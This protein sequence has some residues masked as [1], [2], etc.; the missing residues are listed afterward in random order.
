MKKP[1]TTPFDM[2][3]PMIRLERS[4][5][6]TTPAEWTS[7]T[8]TFVRE[9][10]RSVKKAGGGSGW[11][12]TEAIIRRKTEAL[13]ASVNK[14]IESHCVGLEAASVLRQGIIE[15]WLRVNS[16][17]VTTYN[18]IEARSHLLVAAAIWILDQ[19]T[20]QPDWRKELYPLL[21]KDDRLLDAMS[22]P[23]IWH[24]CYE[25]DL[26][27]SVVYVLVN[28][29]R[30]VAPAEFDFD[31]MERT[32][33]NSLNAAGKQHAD[34][35]SRRAFDALMGMISKDVIDQAVEHFESLFWRWVDRYLNCS[36]RQ[37]IRIMNSAAGINDLVDEFNSLRDTLSARMREADKA[38]QKKQQEARNSK[39][40]GNPLLVNP[41]PQ[42]KDIESFL[43]MNRRASVGETVLPI[44]P[45]AFMDSDPVMRE[46]LDLSRKMD[47][48]QDQIDE[49]GKEFDRFIADKTKFTVQMLRRGH[50]P[51][52]EIQQEYL[53]DFSDEMSELVIKDPYEACF[54]L[55][56]L[57][58]SGSDLP[59]LYG[60]GAGLMIEVAESLPWG[61]REYDEL[62]DRIWSEPEE[63]QLSLFD[64]LK[65]PKPGKPADIP[66]WYERRYLPGRNGQFTFKRSL[67]QIL[68]EETGCIMPRDLHRY[69][70]LQNVLKG[71]GIKGKDS[72]M[73]LHLFTAL[74]HARRQCHAVNL[75]EELMAIWDESS[76]GETTA[77]EQKLTYDELTEQFRQA[78]TENKRIRDALHDAEKATREVRKQ[79]ASIQE[80]E[81]LEHRELA[82]L[83][84]LVFRR[85]NESAEE[86]TPVD[87]SIFPDEVQHDTVVFGGHETWLKA[88]RAMLTGNIRFIDK[89][90]VFDTNI[91]RNAEMIWIQ[92]NALSHK[93]FYRIIDAAR[94]YKI[95]VRYFTWAS[96]ARGARQVAE[97]DGGIGK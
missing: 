16:I 12:M 63:E 29:D 80:T 69:D 17:P 57:V 31:N 1:K 22:M 4:C 44:Q 47:Q 33:T 84:E 89:D 58:E 90:L 68:Y 73:M 48:L 94:Q 14:I 59:W 78:K 55:L 76:P 70:E 86:E 2:P 3:K 53:G 9:A 96:A 82:D 26:I 71:Y 42:V 23:D 5:P 93:Q 95:P 77:H 64:G 72:Q 91:I 88:I 52:S 24:C 54:A 66:D 40:R 20:L 85:E 43:E 83:R 81:K 45:L 65:A 10:Q 79:L 60:A 87:E 75:D 34:V 62:D 56:W 36:I 13:L 11:D 92:N 37:E 39:P 30:D 27:L 67:A 38:R 15:S 7:L 28:R 6:V 97:G 21:P 61:G 51:K 41:A 50:I 46:T 8:R 35:P 18:Q 49:N 25:Y 32:I 74:G 19:I